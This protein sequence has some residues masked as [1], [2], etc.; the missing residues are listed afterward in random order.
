MAKTRLVFNDVSSSVNPFDVQMTTEFDIYQEA[1]DYA[2]T[3]AYQFASGALIYLYSYDN[4][5][6]KFYKSGDA[7]A[8]DEITFPFVNP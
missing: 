4:T 1:Y 6:Y 5:S 3:T 8:T 2:L 7:V